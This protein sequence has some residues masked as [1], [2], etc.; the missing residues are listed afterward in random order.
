MPVI[1]TADV[2]VFVSV[3]V[4]PG[5]VVC[6]LIFPNDNVVGDTVTVSL[7]PVPVSEIDCGLPGALSLTV[8]D[9][10]RGPVAVGSK[11]TLILQLDPAA[12]LVP[13]LLVCAKSVLF[14][15]V[16]ARLVIVSV[17]FPVLVRVAVCGELTTPTDS[18]PKG[19]LVGAN[20]TTGPPPVPV[21]VRLTV[22]GLFPA[23]SLTF[24]VAV[25]VPV[26]DG[27]NVTFTVQAWP[28]ATV[29]PHVLVC[30]KSDAFAPVKVKLLMLSVAICPL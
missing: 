26:A 17:A 22:C 18:F 21:P 9:A 13:Q 10:F 30:A 19:M 12:T 20:T 28:A 27:V 23:S 14:S 24:N 15:P 2:L 25:R 16:T 1:V 3:T 5:L 11:V 29:P 8:T 7:T 4:L 6:R